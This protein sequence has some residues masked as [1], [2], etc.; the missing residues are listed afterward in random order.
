MRLWKTAKFRKNPFRTG[1]SAPFRTLQNGKTLPKPT[2][3]TGK[4]VGFLPTSPLLRHGMSHLVRI[5]VSRSPHRKTFPTEPVEKR[6]SG[7]PPK[8]FPRFPRS[9]P[10]PRE[11]RFSTRFRRPFRLFRA[12]STTFFPFFGFFPT[13]FPQPVESLWKTIRSCWKIPRCRWKPPQIQIGQFP[14]NER[15]SRTLYRHAPPG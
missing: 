10:Q 7:I 1:F 11:F 6:I 5:P 9:F 13:P 4:T 8:S 3:I 15:D 14:P 2:E 12:V